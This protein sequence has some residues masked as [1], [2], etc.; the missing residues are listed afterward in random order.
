MGVS[1]LKVFTSDD[2]RIRRIMMQDTKSILG[3][4]IAGFI[5]TVPMTCAMEA[6][7][8]LLPLYERRP[9]PPRPVT[10]NVADY[11]GVQD[12]MSECACKNMTLV[13]HLGM[14]AAM[15]GIYGAVSTIVPVSGPLA[16]VGAGL[17][18]WAGNYLGLLPATGVLAPATRHP[19]RPTAVMIAAHVVWGVTAGSLLAIWQS[20]Q[21]L[22]RRGS[23]H[24][25]I[26][27]RRSTVAARRSATLG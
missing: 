2:Q 27:R 7:S 25:Q 19:A 21:K 10:M 12:E 8:R 5:A 1:P 3:G 17:G 26:V 15:G 18:V 11:V 23:R 20:E 9:L 6:L 16:G 13:S 14:G 24:R 22:R 4:A